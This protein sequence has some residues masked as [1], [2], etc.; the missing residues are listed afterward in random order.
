MPLPVITSN[1]VVSL[2]APQVAKTSTG[3]WDTWECRPVF[4]VILRGS[5]KLVVKAELAEHQGAA[6]S[7]KFGAKIMHNLDSS[8]K[9]ETLT[10]S[11][12]QV[13][14]NVT[15]MK[16]CSRGQGP[17]GGEMGV[18][19]LNHVRTAGAHY[20]WLK[21]L[22]VDDL[23][24]LK[25]IF[26]DENAAR[27]LLASMRMD[28]EIIESLGEVVAG[29]IFIGNEDRF[30]HGGKGNVGKIVNDGNILFTNKR[31]MVIKGIGLD[32]FEAQG[33]NVNLNTAP[34]A[35]WAGLL[36][37]DNA[38]LELF[39]KNAVDGINEIFHG[40]LPDLG[41][42]E[43]LTMQNVANFKD[44]LISGREK[45]KNYLAGRYQANKSVPSGVA[46]RMKMLNWL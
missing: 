43:L 15:S 22:Y 20:T 38:Q 40:K 35:N 25:G 18:E 46:A 4:F 10:S 13:L 39:S 45:L 26:K 32:W 6:K 23:V 3:N 28:A 33:D 16:F 27:G 41:T 1:N 17:Q 7:V 5:G 9:A 30:S 31:G 34:G 36:L 8:T 42:D 24:D 29:D 12:L 2:K 19:Y 44:G 37:N 11:E 14:G 21:M